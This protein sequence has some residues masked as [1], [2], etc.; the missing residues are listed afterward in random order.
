[1]Q[2]IIFFPMVRCEKTLKKRKEI[3]IGNIKDY[4]KNKKKYTNRDMGFFFTSPNYILIF[5]AH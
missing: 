4:K 5:E 3:I 1:M 2:G